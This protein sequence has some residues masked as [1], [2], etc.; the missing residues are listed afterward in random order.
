M[1]EQPQQLSHIYLAQ[2]VYNGCLKYS[3]NGDETKTREGARKRA[4][5][6][7]KHSIKSAWS[8]YPAESVQGL[9][10]RWDDGIF[11]AAG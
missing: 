7:R 2:A 10:L 1:F 6:G 4:K 11:I 3:N 9:I 8:H 5:C